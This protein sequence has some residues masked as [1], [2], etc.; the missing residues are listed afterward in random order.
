MQKSVASFREIFGRST[1]RKK[2]RQPNRGETEPPPLGAEQLY[3]IVP[4]PA[5]DPVV[6]K[7]DVYIKLTDDVFYGAKVYR[8]QDL[9]N[10]GDNHM[11]AILLNFGKDL[12]PKSARYSAIINALKPNDATLIY[13]KA[14][15]QYLSK[16]YLMIGPKDVSYFV[17]TKYH[18][19]L[20]CFGARFRLV[21]IISSKSQEN[22]VKKDILYAH[23]F[24]WAYQQIKFNQSTRQNEIIGLNSKRLPIVYRNGQKDEMLLLFK[25]EPNVELALTFDIAQI[26][27]RVA[28]ESALRLNGNVLGN[29]KVGGYFNALQQYGRYVRNNN[30]ITRWSDPGG[31]NVEFTHTSVFFSNMPGW[32]RVLGLAV[33]Q[34]S[35]SYTDRRF[36]IQYV[37]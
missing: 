26:Y 2:Q 31:A 22:K 35:T 30:L 28:C 36:V 10:I 15:K 13:P 9:P 12:H 25:N 32:Y 20:A 14:D 8:A 18:M 1:R 17:T 6:L 16:C 4:A 27:K 33:P 7:C 11:L 21:F 37:L 5:E 24:Q 29:E 3:Q 23:I 19:T 34:V